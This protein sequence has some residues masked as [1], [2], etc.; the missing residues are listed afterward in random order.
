MATGVGD[1]GGHRRKQLDARL[2]DARG[3]EHLQPTLVVRPQRIQNGRALLLH[4]RTG[5][6]P[7]RMD[8]GVGL[9]EVEHLDDEAQR[10]S[11]A[12]DLVRRWKR[13]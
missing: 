1:H 11:P 8:P 12:G 13:S 2:L 6:E 9:D 10:V 4:L 7:V 3:D 5:P